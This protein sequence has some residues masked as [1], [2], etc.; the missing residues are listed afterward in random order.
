MVFASGRRRCARREQP[1]GQKQRYHHHAARGPRSCASGGPARSRLLRPAAQTAAAIMLALHLRLCAAFVSTTP[2]QTA[3]RLPQARNAIAALR[4]YTGGQGGYGATPLGRTPSPSLPL[5]M[6][7]ATGA[8]ASPHSEVE[9]EQEAGHSR[10]YCGDLESPKSRPGLCV[11]SAG[12]T[13]GVLRVCMF[14]LE[15]VDE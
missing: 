4:P 5:T 13:L 15:Q 2:A 10:R 8:A 9:T 6:R 11:C 7:A 1:R 3:A 12:R 14:V